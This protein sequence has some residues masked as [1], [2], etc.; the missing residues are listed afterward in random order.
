MD[1]VS[2]DGDA[3]CEPLPA[4]G[5]PS[6]GAAVKLGEYDIEFE[7]KGLDI[8]FFHGPDILRKAQREEMVWKAPLFEEYP[9]NSYADTGGSYEDFASDEK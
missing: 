7:G 5:A 8:G 4:A 2:K 3:R 6:L 1:T 9:D